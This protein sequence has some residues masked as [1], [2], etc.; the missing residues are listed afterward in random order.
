MPVGP[1]SERRF[2]LSRVVW[3]PGHRRF[4][5]ESD[6]HVRGESCAHGRKR[7]SL[8]PSVE[9]PMVRR[10]RSAGQGIVG[11]LAAHPSVS[12]RSLAGRFGPHRRPTSGWAT[13]PEFSQGSGGP[14]L[15]RGSPAA[16]NAHVPAD[17]LAA[18]IVRGALGRGAGCAAPT[19]KATIVGKV[20]NVTRVLGWV[21]V[22]IMT[23][24][25]AVRPG[26]AGAARRGRRGPQDGCWK[27]A[28]CLHLVS[29]PH[30]HIAVGH[31]TAGGLT[32]LR[33]VK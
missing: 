31:A 10:P 2:A 21:A 15:R 16:L 26:L 29:S 27:R 33:P 22:A 9:A 6:A 8:M 5:A 14:S 4:P 32:L 24:A 23:C 18:Q 1:P 20:G 7:K 25:V 30:D 19:R 3:W 13:T 11:A 12:G 28:W 17:Q